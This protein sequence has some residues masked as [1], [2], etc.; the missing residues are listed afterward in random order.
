[1]SSP[2]VS[3]LASAFLSRERRNCADLTGQRALLTPDCLPTRIFIVSPPHLHTYQLSISRICSNLHPL[4]SIPYLPGFSGT[5]R[6]Q[7]Y[8][9]SNP[10]SSPLI[11]TIERVSLTLSTSSGTA[12]I[13]SHGNSLLVSNH[14]LEE[15][16]ST[17]QLESVD[18]LSSL[19]GVLEAG[20]K[21]GAASAGALCAGRGLDS[22]TD[23][24]RK[25][26]SIIHQPTVF[27]HVAHPAGLILQ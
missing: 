5:A 17:L 27:S 7:E 15:S 11:Q 1:M 20:S 25:T 24:Y 19:T 23:L 2:L 16:H 6:K 13:S 22:V 10:P 3:A 18:G 4:T 21:I 9:L 14:I 26:T 12:G 8:P